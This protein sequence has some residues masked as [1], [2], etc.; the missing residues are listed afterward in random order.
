[1]GGSLG[2]CT[3]YARQPLSRGPDVSDIVGKLYAHLGVA[4]A[5]GGRATTGLVLI[6][7]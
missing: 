7:R 6:C 1:M 2:R 4:V 5:Q 3:D